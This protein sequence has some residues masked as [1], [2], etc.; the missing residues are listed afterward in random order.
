MDFY[1]W[2]MILDLEF[3]NYDVVYF[4]VFWHDMMML[5]LYMIS[6]AFCYIGYIYRC[7]I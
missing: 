3:D 1:Y 5:A 6:M 4:F 2:F 7:M